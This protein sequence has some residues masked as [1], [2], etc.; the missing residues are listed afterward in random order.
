LFC[1]PSKFFQVT[2]ANQ[3]ALEALNERCQRIIGAVAITEPLKENH[4]RDNISQD[5]KQ[6][7][8]RLGRYDK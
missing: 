4:N 2:Q 7:I 6:R 8:D 1:D 3:E 5:L